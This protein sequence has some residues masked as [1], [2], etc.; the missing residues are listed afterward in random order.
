M[1]TLE[2]IHERAATKSEKSRSK[3]RENY[4]LAKDLGFSAS[5]AQLIS[6]WSRERII[7]LAKTR[8]V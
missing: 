2:D 8:R 5:E 3:L 1:D 7:A 6:H 4:R